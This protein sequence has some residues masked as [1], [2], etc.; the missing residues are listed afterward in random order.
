V[1]ENPATRN[2]LWILLGMILVSFVIEVA[3][4]SVTGRQIHLLRNAH[5][6]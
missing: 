3:Y 2:H 1:D 4:R 5:K 6:E